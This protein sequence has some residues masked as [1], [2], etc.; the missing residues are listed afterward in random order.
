MSY[1]KDNFLDWDDEGLDLGYFRVDFGIF[2]SSTLIKA[3]IEGLILQLRA[4][5]LYKNKLINMILRNVSLPKGGDL[6]TQLG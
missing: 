4:V 6:T 3:G 5:T 2:V 1:G